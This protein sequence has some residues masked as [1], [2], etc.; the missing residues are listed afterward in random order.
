MASTSKRVRIDENNIEYICVDS[1]DEQTVEVLLSKEEELYANDRIDLPI[2]APDVD[3]TATDD[4]SHT[5][6]DYLCNLSESVL[7]KLNASAEDMMSDDS[8]QELDNEGQNSSYIA[9]SGCSGLKSLLKEIPVEQLLE[10]SFFLDQVIFAL[11]Q[12]FCD[13]FYNSCNV[14]LHIRRKTRYKTG[15]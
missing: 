13:C 9:P 4:I 10:T 12:K 2:D 6:D 3:I 11:D 15:K 14:F 7:V 8:E 5:D 1:D